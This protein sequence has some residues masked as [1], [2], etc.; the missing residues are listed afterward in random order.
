[1]TALMGRDINFA[2]NHMISKT[3]PPPST[4]PTDAYPRMIEG[5]EALQG[6]IYHAF[7]RFPLSSPNIDF[8][9]DVLKHMNSLGLE[10]RESIDDHVRNSKVD[11]SLIQFRVG[12]VVYHKDFGFRAVVIGWK[13]NDDKDKA[14]P[15]QQLLKVLVD[16]RDLE[17]HVKE[18][19]NDNHQF[20]EMQVLY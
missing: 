16:Q 12:Q 20:Q 19:I 9:F 17:Q 8:G 13:I 7:R 1:M 14:G 3:L 5:T 10:V 6:L 15:P 18:T 4:P 2:F 11:P